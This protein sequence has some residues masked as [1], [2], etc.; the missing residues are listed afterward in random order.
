[1]YIYSERDIRKADNQA[2]QTGLNIVA[3]MENAGRS[4]YVEIVQHIRKEDRILVLAGK[5]NNGGDGIVLSRYLQKNGY[6]IELVFPIGKPKTEASLTHLHIY[7]QRDQYAEKIEGS[8]DVIIDALLG[9]GTK[10]PLSQDLLHII[11]WA[12]GQQALR[13]SVDMPTGVEADC[14]I[15]DIAFHADYTVALHGLKPSAFLEP[16]AN[17]YGIA[18]AVEIGLPHEAEWRIWTEEDVHSSFPVR[19]LASH[20]GTYGTGLL[21]AGSDEMP[22][23]AMLSGIGALRSGIGKLVIA[24]SSFAAQ[25]IAGKL[26]EATYYFDGM[27]KVIAGQFP[28][29]MLAAAIGPG[30]EDFDAVEFALAKLFETNIPLVIDAGALHKRSYP[31]REAPIILTPHPGE[32]CRIAGV[33]MS[34]LQANRLHLSSEF[35]QQHGVIVVL[36]GANTVIAFPDGTGFVNKS[37]NA[38]LAKGGSGDMLTGMLLAFLC[39]HDDPKAAVANAVYLHGACADEW[40]K[41][42]AMSSLLASDFSELLPTVLKRFEK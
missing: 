42:H 32:F 11:Q 28:E 9:V 30:L 14:G 6:N 17:F 13:I 38:S 23:S 8:F 19:P 7:E 33:N 40:V 3:L 25:I 22:G 37:G 35:A 18:K 21:I 2:V 1:M 24:T 12:N 26:P 36:K 5:G 34:E 41:L 39:T 16:S 4:L 20:K 15:T 27:T 31:K 29:K 10:L